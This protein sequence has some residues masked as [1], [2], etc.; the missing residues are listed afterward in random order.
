[1]RI[2]FIQ[3]GDSFIPTLAISMPTY[4]GHL[5]GSFISTSYS[6]KFLGIEYVGSSFKGKS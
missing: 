2:A 5:V 1:M 6:G 4:L 3:R